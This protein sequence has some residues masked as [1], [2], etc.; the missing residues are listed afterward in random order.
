MMFLQILETTENADPATLAISNQPRGNETLVSSLKGRSLK[1]LGIGQVNYHPL[2]RVL[3][4][5]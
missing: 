1:S 2:I 5:S 3:L 4:F